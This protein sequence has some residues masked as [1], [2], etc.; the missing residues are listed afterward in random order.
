MSR[1][2]ILKEHRELIDKIRLLEKEISD[3][4][5]RSDSSWRELEK[6]RSRLQSNQEPLIEKYWDQLPA[7]EMGACP[8]CKEPVKRLFDQVDMQGFWWMDRTQRPRP[9]PPTCKHFC[10]L[11]GAVDTHG[12]K[13]ETL[14]ESHPGP[15]KPFIVPRLLELPTME[16]V[17]GKIPMDCGYTAYPIMYFSKEKLPVKALTQ[18]WGQKLYRFKTSD[19]QSGWDIMEDAFDFDISSWIKKGR[20]H[21]SHF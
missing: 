19:G 17:I 14:F 1:E 15:S 18:S 2:S 13:V 6:E 10:L 9:E 5:K 21:G 4:I 8:F 16:V 3:R 7:V 12:E 11:M 20:V